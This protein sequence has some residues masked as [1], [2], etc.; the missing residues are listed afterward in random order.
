MEDIKI[1]SIN[2]FINK[3]QTNYN[4]IDLDLLKENFK[5]DEGEEGFYKLSLY[6]KTVIGS[7]T[8]NETY[9]RPP[10]GPIKK[11]LYCSFCGSF[12]PNDHSMECDFPEEDSLYLTLES[13]NSMVLSNP[14]YKGDYNDIKYKFKNNTLNQEDL[15]EILLTPDEI[16][17]ENGRININENEE[18]LTNVSYWGIYKKR[19]PQKLASKT[20]T[21]NFLNNLMISYELQEVKTSIRISKNGLINLINI[22]KDK[23]TLETMMTELINRLN[24]SGAVNI[25]EF[26]KVSGG[27][28]QYYTKIEDKSYI[29]SATSQFY[30]LPFEMN[31][32]INF[33]E[34]D[35]LISPY[36]NSGFVIDGVY[37]RVET[38]KN[39]KKIIYLDN[40]KIIDWNFSPGRLTRNNVLT[41]EY[42][43]FITTP[44]PGIKITSVINKSGIV[45]MSISYCNEK[46]ILDGFCEPLD[47]NLI[48][49]EYFSGVRFALSKIFNKEIELL[50]KKSLENISE[51]GP[52]IYN[53]VSGYAP[54]GKIC[55]LTRTR[56][57][58]DSNYKEGMRPTPY[59]WKGKCPD[60]NYQYLKPEG[61]QDKDGLWYPCCE[62]KNKES[63][64]RM[65]NYLITGFPSN[66]SEKIKFNIKDLERDEGSGILIP[67]SNSIN[68]EANVL[69][70]GVYERVTII[71]KLK[72]ASNEYKVKTKKG[73]IKIINGNDFE[74][75]SRYFPGLNSFSR[76]Q[77]L[78]CILKNL[79][80]SKSYVSI[81]G[82]ILIK[83]TTPFNE[84]Y[85]KTYADYTLQYID[86]LRPSKTEFTYNSANY[87]KTYN[88][89][90]RSVPGDSFNFLLV[91]S[92]IGN[93]YINRYLNVVESQISN[94]FSK[95][96]IFDGYLSVND[97]SFKNEYN[98]TDILYSD[99]NLQDLDFSDRY[100]ILFDLQNGNPE[101][102]SINEE[103][104]NIPDVYGN[105]IE[106]S[107]KELNKAPNNIL[108]FLNKDNIITWGENNLYEDVL[109]LQ[110]LS[111]NKETIEF[112]YDNKTI[113]PNIGLD[114][115]KKYTFN[116]RDIPED[117]YLQ[118]YFNIKINRD[119]AG[120]VVPNRKISIINKTTKPNISFEIMIDILLIKFNN[121]ELDF[122]NKSSE[123]WNF[124]DET[125]VDGGEF[126]VS[127]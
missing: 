118:D 111:K 2:M 92:P 97:V 106:G 83:D 125:L 103:I 52:V 115:I 54:S 19:G 55:R 59:S 78:N 73:E 80:K 12:G 8:I 109:K 70:D 87:F 108:V 75:D 28:Y 91:L 89:T 1:N 4:I 123:E 5:L 6:K 24:N 96:Y 47:G 25:E 9:N 43:K 61:V 44:A 30:I 42:I 104:I 93:F 105:I 79:I 112:G 114:F 15:N 77:L 18:V 121:I 113:P 27:N 46:Q 110:I 119:F 100:K 71:K 26:N 86:V 90:V 107:Y 82:K 126:L 53:T 21:S 11:G 13:F 7:D 81:D 45:M 127:I 69:I 58:G 84:K 31:R 65:K 116:K 64:Q 16:K 88:Y 49:L 41:K 99:I 98:I 34:L 60:P 14:E 95:T 62:T 32:E 23:D 38:I 17:V 76:D 48:K 20:T 101:F 74:R 40:I 124:I 51:K 10:I 29:H 102:N 117:L 35:N 63:I 66:E 39:N 37:T 122:F 57:S 72:K 33:E 22:P 56:D 120:N 94:K 50:T 3:F 67:G 36:D 68:S 85:E